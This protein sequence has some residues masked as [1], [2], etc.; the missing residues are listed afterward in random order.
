MQLVTNTVGAVADNPTDLLT[1]PPL[2]LLGSQPDDIP[3]NDPLSQKANNPFSVLNNIPVAQLTTN[4]VIDGSL[5]AGASSQSS[6]TNKVPLL[7]GVTG[8]LGQTVQNIAG[9]LIDS[10]SKKCYEKQYQLQG[11]Y[12]DISF[13]FKLL[14]TLLIKD[15]S[16]LVNLDGLLLYKIVANDNGKTIKVPIKSKIGKGFHVLSFCP[17]GALT[18]PLFSG[19]ISNLLITEKQCLPQWG[20]ELIT[21]GGFENTLC[22]GQMCYFTTQNFQPSYISGWI[23]TPEIKIERALNL[24]INLGNSWVIELDASKNTC[25]RQ[26]LNIK[27]G[28]YVM[29]FDWAARGG[30]P[31]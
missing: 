6:T 26:F 2:G 11:D 31:F 27:I 9:I 30:T 20:V 10:S 1:N 4:T 12:I 13:N 16:I 17:Q 19:L 25:I 14:T 23:P 3:L 8:L 5:L 24:N 18:E 21:N 28:R 15:S 22:E 29:K 7:G